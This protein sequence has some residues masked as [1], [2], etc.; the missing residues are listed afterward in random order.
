M[1]VNSSR[2]ELTR[3]AIAVALASLWFAGCRGVQSPRQA[4]ETDLRDRGAL[5]LHAPYR[6]SRDAAGRSIFFGRDTLRSH[7]L[8]LRAT[9]ES[10]AFIHIDEKGFVHGAGETVPPLRN[11]GELLITPEES[12]LFIDERPL[13]VDVSGWDVFWI[14]NAETPPSVRHEVYPTVELAD[15]FMRS[16][17]TNEFCRVSAS[18]WRLRQRGGGMPT[19]EEDYT[20]ASFQRAVNPF[21][22][23]GEKGGRLTYG[24][25][26][27][28]NYQAEACFYF[29]IPRERSWSD[30]D[31]LPSEADMLL[32][33]GGTNGNE[34]AFGWSGRHRTFVLMARKDDAPWRLLDKWDGKRPP[35]TNWFRLGLRVRSGYA[36]EA[37]LDRVPIFRTNL[38][39]RIAGP[40]HLQAG[41]QAVEADSI[42]AFSLPGQEHR[43]GRIYTRSRF[44]AA[45]KELGGRDPTQFGE[46]SK[47]T[48]AFVPS[49]HTDSNKIHHA[50]ITTRVP[51]MGDFSY[52]SVPFADAV[53]EIP[54]GRYAFAFRT[55]L[56][57][58][59]KKGPDTPPDLAF[60]AEL[61]EEGWAAAGLP[62]AVWPEERRD[63]ALHF[64]RREADGN[65]IAVWKKGA[66]SPVSA[67]LEGPLHISIA[68][69]EAKRKPDFPAPEHHEIR[70]AHFVNELFEE[71]PA[72]WSWIEGAFRMDCRWACQNQWNFMACGSPGV[73]YMTSKRTFEGD[74]VHECYMSLRPAQ[75]C[76][77]W[78]SD[79]FYDRAKDGSL[80]LFRANGGWYVRRDLNVAFCT[81]GRDPLSG[82]SIVF[83]GDDNRETR[84]LREGRVVATTNAARF[85]FKGDGGHSNVHWKWWKFTAHKH[86]NRIR[87]FLNGELMFDF[88]DRDPLP[89]GHIG[90]WSVRN[91]FTL[92][93]VVSAAE[94]VAQA[95][96][97][98]Y[99]G[100]DTPSPWVP[101][102][103]DSVTLTPGKKPGLT[104]VAANVGAGFLAVRYT[105]P[106][107]VD[108]TATPRMSLPLNF[109]FGAAINLHLD[110]G[111]TAYVIPIT[112]PLSGMK[113]LLAPEFEKG[114]CF[115]IPTLEETEILKTRYLDDARM[116]G[117]TVS[118]DLMKAL[119]MAEKKCD[120]P[121]LRSVT[122]GNAS[123]LGYLLAGADGRNRA[124]TWYEVG[125]PRFRRSE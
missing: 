26:K 25:E 33:Q 28:M 47:S 92:S 96:H 87:C 110:I 113:G 43:G 108:L 119:E 4:L 62:A 98:L 42:R 54:K 6:L 56:R 82:Y 72:D 29:G 49:R 102:Q 7:A 63:F 61:T 70:S 14:S 18:N 121:E 11:W 30:A 39:A 46:W 67:P 122:V 52:E 77:A 79:F 55:G 60:E 69:V 38:A 78:D 75:P 44:F 34:V 50:V 13:P 51:L 68:R 22:I 76:D 8:F 120:K 10:E 99:V 37:A 105:P 20:S 17:L 93:R 9:G 2:T 95:P 83:G 23:I 86:G 84:L 31:T 19:A 36:V 80:R 123:N 45:K 71:A 125:V 118:I 57:E 12:V 90:F 100:N 106:Q 64:T 94:R 24:T 27:W 41:N 3:C 65:R 115:R 111:G 104:R 15:G 21:S 5:L 91:A 89:G 116:G 1:G 103:R 40:F 66:P 114:E 112:A 53:G 58:V 81:N 59:A 35:L 74:Q 32:V 48:S 124:G 117:G 73:P 107:P 109:A 85:L 88:I 16:E 97:V 101:M